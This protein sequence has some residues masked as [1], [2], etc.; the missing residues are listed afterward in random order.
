MYNG[1]YR[2]VSIRVKSMDKR[3][4]ETKNPGRCGEVAEVAVIGDSTV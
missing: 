3:T 4:I 2:E 1:R